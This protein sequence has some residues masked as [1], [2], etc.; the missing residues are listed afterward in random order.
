MVHQDPLVLSA[1]TRTDLE[2]GGGTKDSTKATREAIG[3]N[4]VVFC[5]RSEASYAADP[6]SAPDWWS[7]SPMGEPR[8]M[9]EISVRESAGILG[10][11]AKTWIWE[12]QVCLF[13]S[14]FSL[15]GLFLFG[16]DYPD[17]I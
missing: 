10:N 16:P 6:A 1:D 15:F 13:V 2:N 11:Y 9:K 8:T 7:G 4:F 17:A 14:L 3:L 12:M 5:E